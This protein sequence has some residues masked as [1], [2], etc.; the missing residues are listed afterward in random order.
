MI[1]TRVVRE[2]NNHGPASW[3]AQHLGGPDPASRLGVK[4]AES[5][6]LIGAAT[7]LR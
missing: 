6:P 1:G 3:E 5:P 2:P 4:E 7:R